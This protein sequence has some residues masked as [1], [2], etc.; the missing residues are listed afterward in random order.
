[1][2]LGMAV[3]TEF[4]SLILLY[5]ILGFFCYCSHLGFFFL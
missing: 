4:V 5:L 2:N 1:M 3:L